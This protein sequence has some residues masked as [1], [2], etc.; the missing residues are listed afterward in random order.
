[1]C[2]II[3]YL[4]SRDAAPI[5]L[6]GL[7]RLEYRGYDSAGVA[8][9]VHN[10]GL[11]LCKRAGKLSALEEA[12]RQSPPEGRIGIGHTR[13]ATHG[14]PTDF[15][16]HPHADCAGNIAVV[17]NG[18]IENY[19]EL[20]SDLVAKGHVFTSE[21][22]TEV[23][24]HLIEEYHEGDLLEAARRAVNEIRGSFAFVVVSADHPDELVAAREHSPLIIG[25]G[26][27]EHFVASDIP[28]ILQ[29]T[30]NV[31]ILKNGEIARVR[32]DSVSVFTFAGEP[33]TKEVFE[34]EWDAVMAE[35]AG[36]DHYM[37]KEIAEQ[38]R[39]MRESLR[40]RIAE[41]SSR[42]LLPDLNLT[43]EDLRAFDKVMIVACGT[44]YHA[45]YA[46]KYAIERLA[47]LPVE[48][49]VASE[50]RYR[51]P[52]VN[53]RTLSLVISQ[54]G[55]TIDTLA[56]LDA[57]RSH[58]AHV[59]AITNV[60]GSSV[61][62]ESHDVLY[63][64]AGPEIAVASTKAYTTQ[65]MVVFLL[66]I[67]MAQ[68]GETIAPERTRELIAALQRLPDQGDEILR[69]TTSIQRVA[70]QYYGC[71][72]FLYLGRG[73]NLPSAL[74]GAL[75]LKEISY[76]HA[77]GYPAGEMKHGPIALVQ[78][79]VPTVAIAVPGACYE[80]MIGN[81]QEVKARDGAVIGIVFQGDHEV[82]AIADHVIEIPPTEELFSPALVALPVQLLAYYCAVHCER[83]IDQPRNLAKSVTV[84]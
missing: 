9:L 43:D 62:R 2:G 57:L 35:K 41:D 66:A 54:S 5:L 11:R 46:G 13:W 34:V 17:H 61:A 58:C 52:V 69:D 84:E 12:L 45:G 79:G 39:A 8:L 74:E 6:D 16:A 1:M 28:A 44:A 76:I 31:H 83:D 32:P 65:L 22:D 26:K 51:D 21:T 71:N 23:I 33:V 42:V 70:Q 3:G 36:Y 40:G 82:A 25:L 4:G 72:D 63:T 29:H 50:L 30:R 14:R 81:V 24:A 18:I 19:A 10:G 55:E 64:Y 75:K 77:E 27:D 78:P 48:V 80:K 38:P 68:A 15:N 49:D 20:K 67:R 56:G 47:R 53:E 60:V 37:L 59:T 73:S 7:K